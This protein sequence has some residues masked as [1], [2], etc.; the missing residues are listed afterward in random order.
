M[1][2]TS[3]R[4]RGRVANAWWLL[5]TVP[6][7]LAASWVPFLFAWIN[8]CGVSGCSGGGYGVSYGPEWASIASNLLIGLLIALA[9]AIPA[10]APLRRR[11]TVGGIVGLSVALLLTALML[12]DK[13][14]HVIR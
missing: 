6:L 13:Y 2:E 11:L 14:G 10:W 1:S 7:A 12:S 8:L 4:S 9:V 5:L 3:P